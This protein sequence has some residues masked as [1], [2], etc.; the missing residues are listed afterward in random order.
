MCVRVRAPDESETV[1]GLTLAAEVSTICQDAQLPI[2]T[3]RNPFEPSCLWFILQVETQQLL[4]FDTNMEDF[5]VKVADAVLTV[6][7]EQNMKVSRN[8]SL[9]LGDCAQYTYLVG[10]A[11]PVLLM[12]SFGRRSLLMIYSAGLCFCFVM[13][14]IL[15]SIGS[16][17]AAYGATAFI[18]IFQL[19]YGVG[20]LPAPWFYPSEINTTRIRTRMQAIASGWNWMAVFAVVKITSISFG[21]FC[22]SA[23]E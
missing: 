15:L 9:I 22:L 3:V 8:L 23:P 6:I 12:D 18:F 1:R 5:S 2:K 19:F 20:W 4:A 11:I 14:T 16:E 17:N 10:S 7:F 13:V 21:G